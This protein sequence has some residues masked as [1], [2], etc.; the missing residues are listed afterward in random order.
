[1]L[2]PLW[3]L[4][5]NAE[6]VLNLV[7]PEP[8]TAKMAGL[9]LKV[10][11]L[12]TPGVVAFETGK[13]FV[14]AQGLFHA[15]T[16]V[17]LVGAPLNIVLNY[18]V[19]WKM[20]WGFVGAGITIACIQNLLPFFLYLYVV[21]IDGKECWGGLSKRAFENWGPMLKLAVPGL[22]MLEAQFLAFEIL[23]LVSAQFG[24]TTLAAQSVIVTITSTTFQLPFPLS[25]A[26]STRVAN[27]IGASLVDAARTSAKVVSR[28]TTP[29]QFLIFP[30]DA[31]C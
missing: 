5:W 24:S 7:I 12:G 17:L 30:D 31:P 15:T 20:G 27:L 28:T 6:L 9:Y 13:R 1:M 23:A 29:H 3:V 2:L 18:V 14:M 26:A 22:I 11:I 19:V 21:F 16:V 4:W 25:I 10:L 8:D